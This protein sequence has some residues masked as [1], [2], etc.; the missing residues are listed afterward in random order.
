[1]AVDN[2]Y[3][4]RDHYFE[5]NPIEKAIDKT[6]DVRTELEK[7][8]KKLNESQGQI[9]SKSE[10]LLLKGRALNILPE[11]SPEALD[12][13]SKAVKLDPKLVEAWNHLGECYWKKKDIENARNC[14]TGALN[15][16]ENKV[17]LRNLSMVLRQLGG[18]PEER[19]KFMQQS[20][21]NI[22]KA[23]QLDFNDGTSWFIA[24]N[25]YLS[26]FFASGQSAS[27]LKQCLGAYAKA[28]KDPVAKSNPDLHF[29]RAAIYRFQEEYHLAIE[30]YERA[31]ALDPLWKEPQEKRKELVNFLWKVSELV[32]LKG[33]LK[34]KKLQQ[35]I[36]SLTEADL[37]PYA[38]GSY[39]GA[40]K[41][42]VKLEP[43][44]LS[45]LVEGKNLEKVVVGKVVC[46]VSLDEPIPF[47]FAIVDSEGSCYVVN[48]YNVAQ[49]QG[50]IIGD[51]VAIPEPHI[52]KNDLSVDDKHINFFSIR[53]L[54]PIYLVVNRRKLG[55]DKQAPAT[56]Q[57]STLGE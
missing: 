21:D 32:R 20:V 55:A 27:I 9:E 24:G 19:S 35:L 33:K 2:L 23:V 34:N 53:V 46:S 5:R 52:M 13:L 48:L 38:G 7:V 42:T 39:T 18:T 8:L 41:E 54:S 1:M 43:C 51:S 11:F 44:P 12:C 47:T 36:S 29:N 17:S 45:K 56:L 37:G 50:V 3:D 49:G 4:F 22:K 28:E 15:Y 40:N 31:T 57:V 14:F 16:S 30:G 26:L 10:F 25:T 6:D